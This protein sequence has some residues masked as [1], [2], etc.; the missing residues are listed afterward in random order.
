MNEFRLVIP[1]EP[2]AKGRPKLGNIGGHARAFTPA[3]TRRYE[4]VVRQRATVEWGGRPLIAE[5]AIEIIATFY[6]AIPQSWSK[7]KRA[8]ALDGSLRPIGRPDA[9]NL[10]KSL[11]DGMNSVIY[12]DDCL[13]T[14]LYAR[15]RYALEPRVEILL[16]W[17]GPAHAAPEP[18][19]VPLPTAQELFAEEKPF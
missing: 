15:K 9:D 6:R 4:D 10:L 12:Y 11:T 13:L 7:A 5:C 18:R 3:K 2:V 1:G 17:D 16:Q 14:D 19:P 8:A